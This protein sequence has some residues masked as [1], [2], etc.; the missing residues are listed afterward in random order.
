VHDETVRMPADGAAGPPQPESG[1]PDGSSLSAQRPAVM[2]AEQAGAVDDTRPV[3]RDWLSGAPD[4]PTDA[5]APAEDAS[6]PAADGHGGTA[7]ATAAATE[8]EDGW[9]TQTID[10]ARSDAVPATAGGFTPVDSPTD[11]EPPSGGVRGPR[12]RRRGVL[13][14]VLLFAVLAVLYGVDLLISRGS[15]A[16]STLVAGV[17][18]GGMSPAAAAG[19]LESEL[20]PRVAAD[21][22]VVA[23][24]VETTLSP[25]AAGISLDVDATVDRADDQP[26]NP[27][28]RLVSLFAEQVLEPVLAVDETALSAQLDGIA[29]QVD[30]APVD[31]T[32]V[33]D[34]T[35][36]RLVEPA[37]G[38]EL[39]RRD[40][41]DA[42]TGA[43]AA[44]ADPADPVGLPVRVSPVHVDAD[45]ARQVLDDTVTPALSAPVAVS[46]EDGTTTAEVPVA[47]IAASLTFTPQENGDLDVAVDPAALQTALGDEL[48]AF[49]TPAKDASFDVSGSAVS[50]VPSVDG[51]GI[52]P[53]QLAEQ[54]RQVLTA[55][56]PRSVTADLGPVPAEF[57][58]EQAQALGIREE[59]ST[60]TT[61]YTAQA[62]GTNM[63]TAAEEIDGT[64]VP[65]GETFSLNEATGPR[66]LA[67]GYVEAGVIS[68][69]DFT[70]SVGG[71]V[72]QLATTIFNAVFFAG[73]EDVHHKPHS[74]YISRYPPGREAT[75]WYDSLDL[76]WRNDSQTGVLVD[77]AWKPGSL[78]VTFYGTKRYEIESITSDRYDITSPAVQEKPDDGDC[79]PAAGS[80]GFSVTVTRV[81]KDP[82]SGAEVRREQFRTRYA[83]QPTVHCVP[84]P[85]PAP[86]GPEGTAEAPVAD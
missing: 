27:W 34:G 47:A 1:R 36:P 71:G 68:G 22:T 73:L 29:E 84:V 80:P 54:L 67:Q 8:P 75:V 20:T 21:R 70:T 66:G 16:R 35:T 4:R 79:Q 86:A 33:I 50:V 24:D 63:R 7:S 5:T 11:D 48:K 44:G 9:A 72:S 69:G 25:A 49:G 83:A 42:I 58:T 59:I 2:P 77:T 12:W 39:D 30:R 45:T 51:T 65:P 56:E 19:A 31:A 81:F 6:A 32:I 57:T 28:T 37:D 61:Q 46:S 55:A 38:R 10:A 15:V 41:A 62:S 40:A 78:T 53:A 74:Y 14:P 52:D 13:V 23:D 76:E 64:I 82:A 26:L 17:D 60:F 3:T 18:I 43:L 85:A